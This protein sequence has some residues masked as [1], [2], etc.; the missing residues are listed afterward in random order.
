MVMGWIQWL[1][2]MTIGWVLLIG[3][4]M[5]PDDPNNKIHAAMAFVCFIAAIIIGRINNL[6]ESLKDKD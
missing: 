2:L 4:W 6:E 3:T 5:N 1:A